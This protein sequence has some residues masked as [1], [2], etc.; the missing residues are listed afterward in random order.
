MKKL[1]KIKTL[2]FLEEVETA[3]G[4]MNGIVKQHGR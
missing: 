2:D 1:F 3:L 4:V